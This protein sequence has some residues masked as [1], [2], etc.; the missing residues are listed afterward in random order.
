MT[1]EES[2]PSLCYV[3]NEESGPNLCYVTNEESGPNLCYERIQVE[4]RYSFTHMSLDGVTWL[5]S[6]PGR[7]IPGER[8]P[9]TN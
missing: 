2:G 8:I 5:V 4:R 3:T 7:F 6:C 1:N 9:G